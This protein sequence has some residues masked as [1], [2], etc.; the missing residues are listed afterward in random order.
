M[1]VCGTREEKGYTGDGEVQEQ[2]PDPVQ[3]L[4]ERCC[5]SDLYPSSLVFLLF[6]PSAS[7]VARACREREGGSDRKRKRKRCMT[8]TSTA[9]ARTQKKR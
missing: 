3:I 6:T 1:S 8:R 2:G 7:V 4:I 9:C 5:R